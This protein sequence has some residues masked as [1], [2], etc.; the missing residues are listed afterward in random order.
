MK[1][2]LEKV[3]F[4]KL[5]PIDYAFMIGG[6]IVFLLIAIFGMKAVIGPIPHP[7]AVQRI[8]D[9]DIKPGTPLTEV[10]HELGEPKSVTPNPD[11]TTTIIYTRTVGDPDLQIEEGIIQV[12]Q[13]GEVLTTTVDRQLPTKPGT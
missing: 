2:N 3:R 8:K 12:T 5:K 10:L 4:P 9:G 1:A 7:S 6:P 11:G 13:S